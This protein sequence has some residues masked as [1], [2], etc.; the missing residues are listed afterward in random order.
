[1]EWLW[2]MI[3]TWNMLRR[4]PGKLSSVTSSWNHDYYYTR[5]LKI[6]RQREPLLWNFEKP[7]AKAFNQVTPSK[8]ATITNEDVDVIMIFW[9]VLYFSFLSVWLI[10]FWLQFKKKKR[11]TLRK[12]FIWAIYLLKSKFQGTAKIRAN[13]AQL[14][15]SLILYPF[16]CVERTDS[17][18]MAPRL[19]KTIHH[20]GEIQFY[21]LDHAL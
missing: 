13:S 17:G 8:H 7:E 16:L 6:F 20:Q 2:G 1:M 14:P 3:I 11:K 21:L 4:V 9:L 15:V 18:I 19:W 12:Q 5:N 10:Y